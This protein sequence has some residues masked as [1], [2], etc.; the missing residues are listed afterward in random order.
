M[1]TSKLVELVAPPCPTQKNPLRSTAAHPEL[2]PSAT[3]V[4][5]PR[6]EISATLRHFRTN[7]SDCRGY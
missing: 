6:G 3:L 4:A 7:G 2:P 5:T 1:C